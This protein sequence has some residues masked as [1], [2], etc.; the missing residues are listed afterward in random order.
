M[1]KIFLII[2]VL[3]LGV[4]LFYLKDTTSLI[5]SQLAFIGSF[6]ITIGSFLGYKRVVQKKALTATTDLSSIDDKYEL[7]E[8]ESPPS[9]PKV[10]FEEEKA[11]IKKFSLKTLTSTASG[12]F[13]LYRLIGYLLLVVFVLWLVRHHLFKPTPFLIGLSV[14]PIAAMISAWIEE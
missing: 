5:N 14:V 4:G 1:K 8:E 3:D 13:S 2:L 12:F 11:K 6:L 9:D 7:Y 10:L